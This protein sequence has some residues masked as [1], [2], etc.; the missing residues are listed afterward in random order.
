MI[1]FIKKISNRNKS[2]ILD[3]FAD[4]SAI[5]N[6]GKKHTKKVKIK[7]NIKASIFIIFVI[8]IVSINISSILEKIINIDNVKA[9]IQ[10]ELSSLTGK[11][12][13][14]KGDIVLNI[15]PK[16]LITIN[17]LEFDEG[18]LLNSTEFVKIDT[19]VV[20]P[21]LLKLFIGKIS[22]ENVQANNVELFMKKSSGQ[23]GNFDQFFKNLY[24]L[25]AKKYN[26]KITNL[27][28]KKLS[29]NIIKGSEEKQ[30]YNTL[31][32][33]DI[34]INVKDGVNF[35]GKSELGLNFKGNLIDKAE[36]NL[37]IKIFTDNGLDLNASGTLQFLDTLKF[38]GILDGYAT[39]VDKDIIKLFLP[40]SKFTELSQNSEKFNIKSDFYI[41]DNNFVLPNVKISND[42]FET[43]AKFGFTFADKNNVILDAEVTKIDFAKIFPD[44]FELFLK[45]LDKGKKGKKNKGLK[46]EAEVMEKPKDAEVKNTE[47]E[48][49]TVNNDVLIAE[50]LVD[51]KEDTTPRVNPI[52][53]LDENTSIA[54][55][56]NVTN[57]TIGKLNFNLSSRFDIDGENFTIAYVNAALPGDTIINLDAALKIDKSKKTITGSSNLSFYSKESKKFI[58]AI[59][60][61]RTVFST[62]TPD[63][64]AMK[65]E[66]FNYENKIHFR[67]IEAAL[68]D[69]KSL[70][71]LV[72]DFSDNK[73]VGNSAFKINKI[74]FDN[75]ASEH[76]HEDASILRKLDFVR[77]FD[78]IFDNF[79]LSLQAD[80][81]DYN[82]KPYTNFSS[83][84]NITD[85]KIYFTD[86]Q[87]NSPDNGD[88]SGKFDAELDVFQPRVNLDFTVSK[89]A[90]GEASNSSTT[91]PILDGKWVEKEI[92]LDK[93]SLITGSAKIA[94]D[95]FIF[96]GIPLK[97]LRL[98]AAL[99]SD[100]IVITKSRFDYNDSKFDF[101]GD[102][103]T[104]FPSLSLN[105]TATNLE[106]NKL[107]FDLINNKSLIGTFNISGN[108]AMNGANTKQWLE[109][110]KGAINF[111][112]TG[113]RVKGFDIDKLSE[114]VSESNKIKEIRFW[115]D[116]FLSNGE[117]VFGYLSGTTFIDDGV[118]EIKDLLLSSPS[119][120]TGKFYTKYDLVKWNTD[121]IFDFNVI[122][123]AGKYNSGTE[124][125]VQIMYN[126]NINS[127]TQSKDIKGIEKYWE[128]KFYQ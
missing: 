23:N 24:K 121:S 31:E 13:I 73:I 122:T 104:E 66:I 43:N 102:M 18:K 103:T 15:V 34:N 93:Y 107:L 1:N 60:S 5:D 74:N 108:L 19:L 77:Y 53:K 9:E 84:V 58:D 96:Y 65:S 68:G 90:F 97:N 39:G 119:L 4:D 52:F 99:T 113:I 35:T 120:R 69:N 127:P 124:F 45:E 89:I 41:N 82:Q 32:L 83:F 67:K 28:V 95:E 117:T 20:F 92:K 63:F 25:D 57:I 106:I 54:A 91:Q 16:A 26:N 7:Q 81:I 78:T 85:G 125:P 42:Y 71:Q 40:S 33:S 115:S 11:N 3:D 98:D 47:D 109:S 6:S 59:D 55:K 101:Y 2:Q 56:I 46:I 80:E 38:N 10:S 64:I 70:G 116:K 22:F 21:N 8:I 100:K 27:D 29:I 37:N 86:M 79:N 51:K 49:K 17:N 44:G 118:F 88:V 128:N 61:D 111:T 14:I 30:F 94:A 50:N 114:K 75:F 72:V 87:M 112:S 123:K 48:A 110:M 12:A 105:F 126:G 76:E 36:N 62:S